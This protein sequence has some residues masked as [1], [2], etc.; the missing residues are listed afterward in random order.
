MAI[1]IGT[2]EPKAIAVGSTAIKKIAVG[3]T[4][5]W[6]AAPDVIYYKPTL[7]S[8]TKN[9]ITVSTTATGQVYAYISTNSVVNNSDV[10]VDDSSP[11]R[12]TF[13]G[14]RSNRNYWI[15]VSSV[16]LA[17]GVSIPSGQV[18]ATKTLVDSVSWSGQLRKRADGAFGNINASRGVANLISGFAVPSAW[19][20]N[21]RTGY[22]RFFELDDLNIWYLRIND[23]DSGT[24]SDSGDDLISS[25]ESTLQVKVTVGSRS[26]TSTL[27][28]DSTEPYSWSPI[29][30][31]STR[32]FREALS[33]GLHQATITLT[34]PN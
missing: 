26:I 19:M 32:N 8:R 23:T 4:E 24:G 21:G 15:G 2:V 18:L 6:S 27:S 34:N 31:S 3:S 28:F 1:N 30:S 9:S 25:L 7:V 29:P 14:L 13:S 12:I 22:V 17:S 11:S 20:A 33:T 16:P 10:R 5:V